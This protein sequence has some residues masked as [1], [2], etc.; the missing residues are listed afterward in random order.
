[1]CSPPAGTGDLGNFLAIL[2]RILGFIAPNTKI[3]WL[4]NFSIFSEPDES[5][6]RNELCALHL[7]STFFLISKDNTWK[8]R[9]K[10]DGKKFNKLQQ[11]KEPPLSPQIIEYT[12]YAIKHCQ[13]KT[14]I[15]TP[16]G[17]N[18]C[19]IKKINN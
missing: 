7:I 10:T 1:M 6:F 13:L 9:L 18:F 17:M 8:Q 3:I 19:I 2:I 15:L 11:F 12:T 14:L 5:C 16:S 4:S